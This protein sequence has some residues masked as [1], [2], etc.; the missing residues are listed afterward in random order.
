MIPITENTVTAVAALIYNDVYEQ[1]PDS[2][3]MAN[4]ENSGPANDDEWRA[5]ARAIITVLQEQPEATDE[6][7]IELASKR[8][9]P[10]IVGYGWNIIWMQQTETG[11]EY[12]TMTEE[13]KTAMYMVRD[14]LERPYMYVEESFL[15]NDPAYITYLKEPA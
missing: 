9:D 5:W 1:D 4:D 12:S 14:F 6:Q 10:K 7:V 8:I 11:D 13:T 15:E 2:G 3:W